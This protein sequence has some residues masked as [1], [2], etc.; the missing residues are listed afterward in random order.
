ILFVAC[1]RRERSRDGAVLFEHSRRPTMK[2]RPIVTLVLCAFLTACQTFKPV[3]ATKPFDVGN[4]VTVE[5]QVAWA[6]APATLSGTVWTIDG[7]GLNELRFL[8]GVAAGAPLMRI[9]GVDRKDMVAYN[10]TMLPDDVMDMTA[11][12]LGKS[13]NQQV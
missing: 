6:N 3:E 9:N 7:F 5:P 1:T 10:A 4:G 8:T 12:T 2:L 13:G 11:S